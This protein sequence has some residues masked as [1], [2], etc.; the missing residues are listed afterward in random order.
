MMNTDDPPP[1]MV[2]NDDNEMMHHHDGTE[3]MPLFGGDDGHEMMNRVTD[4]PPAQQNT[5]DPPPMFGGND[6]HEMMHHGNNEDEEEGFDYTSINE[7]ENDEN[8][9]EDDPA[10]G[11]PDGHEPLI[12][13]KRPLCDMYC[14]FG[15]QTDETGC[16]VCRCHEDPCVVR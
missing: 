3:K 4:R 8:E 10:F 9:D 1:S 16:P 12:R 7:D 2:D 11:R 6:S 15:M 13:C 5:N 14:E